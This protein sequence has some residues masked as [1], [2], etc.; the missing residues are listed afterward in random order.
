MI[1]RRL[2][3]VVREAASQYPVVTITGP[4]QSGKTTL[5]RQL[6]PERPYLTL[7]EPDV[8][9][10]ATQDPR[11]FLAAHAAGAVFD[12]VQNVP[13]LLSWLQG[14]VD[15]RDDPGRFI[16]TGSAN[17]PL[18]EAV[19]QSLAG[20]TAMLQLLPPSLDELRGFGPLADLWS[21]VWRG[22]YPRI[23]DR[24]IPPERW[25]SDYFATY[26]QRDVRQLLNIG[27]VNTFSTFVRLCAGRTASE[28]NFSSLGGD[29]GV[30]HN[31]AR[32]W[33]SVM[34]ASFLVFRTPPWHQNLRKQLVK[35]PKLHFVD[36]GLVC[37]LLGIRSPAELE[38]HPLRGSIFE[39]WV[40]A[41][42]YKAFAHAGRVPPLFHWRETRGFEVDLVVERGP[43]PLLA[44]VKSGQTAASDAIAALAEAARSVSG[45][46]WLVHGGALR[47]QRTDVDVRG[48]NS[49]SDDAWLGAT[50][51]A[52]R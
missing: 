11:G 33:L 50:P 30:S 37:W 7:E 39:S 32:S 3:R 6:F 43:R 15:R 21:V 19:A 8:R 20:R 34:E 42:A 44:E 46:A 45:E 16:L 23:H 1:E 2:E 41:E 4:R 27:D 13:E 25:F 18:V 9:D 22:A 52:Q 49:L 24:G 48:W 35:T 17:L 10:W 26:V 28:L 40:A 31:T 5:C 47:Q 36:S 38:F 12:E 29:A 14:E 51:E